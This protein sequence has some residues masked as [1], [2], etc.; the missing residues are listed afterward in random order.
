MKSL[1]LIFVILIISSCSFDNKTGLWKDASDIPV[2][3]QIGKSIDSNEVQSQYEDIFVQDQI[4]NKEI[5]TKSSFFFELEAP[6]SSSKWLEQFGSKTN[7][8]SNFNYS[9]NKILL[10]KSSKLNKLTTNKNIVFYN[11]NLINFDHKGKIFI[12]SLDSKKKIFE[13][14]F[15]KKKFKNFIK[16]IFFTVDKNILYVADNLG[17]LY[18]IN[19]SSN[20]LIWAKNYGIPFRSNIKI[21]GEQIFLANQDNVIYS[22]DIKTGDKNWEY[23]TT[24]TFLK[25]DFKNNFVIDETSN[26]F[27]F[28]NTSGELYAIDYVSEKINWLLNFKNI[29]LSGDTDLFLSQPIVFKNNSLIIS[30][31]KSVLSLNSFNGSRNWILKSRPILKPILT[32]NYT[33]ILSKNDLIICIENKIGNVLWSKNVFS[34]INN[35]TMNKI[36]KFNDIKIVNNEI[37]LFTK[38]GYLLSFDYK[39]G[40]LNY[41]KKISKNGISS[42]IVFL[43]DNMLLIDNNNKLLKFN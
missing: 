41:I 18:A 7:N 29:S 34:S 35:R 5:N 3:N 37:N 25:S 12:Y 40:N 27:F 38:N 26:A 32:N 1:I 8:T 22:I 11:N 17:Y 20:S 43:K 33:Y 24:L 39:N 10:S 42:E 6:I 23:A 19:L 31:E 9:G 21:V 15:Y 4:F 13:Y 2:D 14:N 28:L 30:T 36:G 16:E